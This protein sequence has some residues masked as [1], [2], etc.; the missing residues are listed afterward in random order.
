MAAIANMID[1]LAGDCYST[2]NF[3]DAGS[4]LV[5]NQ[6]MQPML[7][8][9]YLVGFVFLAIIQDWSET[10]GMP[11]FSFVYF[12][13][14]TLQ[15]LGLL[16]LGMRM[17]GSKSVAG[18][19]SQSLV[20]FTLSLS[21]RVMVTSV[22]EGYLPADST[23]D[24]LI[25]IVDACSLVV[26]IYLLYLVHKPF[27]HTYQS[28]HDTLSILPIVSACLVSAFFIH[29]DLNRCW[30]FDT[31][32]A[33]S[34]NVEIFQMLP[35]LFMLAKVGGLVDSVTVHYVVL[36]FLA[37][38]CRLSFWVW[39]VPGSDEL[40]SGEGFTDLQLGAYY[41]LG[42]YVFEIAIHLDFVAHCVKS[43]LQGDKHVSL[44]KLEEG[45]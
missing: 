41:I 6:G 24:F 35:Q 3:S 34:L 44:P 26:V 13:G 23:G 31:L 9:I 7:L 21:A 37:A 15:L 42:G 2:K 39:A 32:W 16:F 20:M 45:M 12:L 10:P 8:M 14:S 40:S 22:Y 19:S 29:A 30:F 1:F 25:Q 28:E 38:I 27:L 17:K 5:S 11:M 33:F 36:T 43:W 18:I 4:K